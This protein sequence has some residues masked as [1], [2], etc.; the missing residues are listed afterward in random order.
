MEG[1]SGDETA[2]ASGGAA[3]APRRWT[4]DACGCHTNTETDTSCSICGT[5]QSGKRFIQRH[6]LHTP[7]IYIA[8]LFTVMFKC[9][10]GKNGIWHVDTENS[11][12]QS[13]SI[14]V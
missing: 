6:D 2:D 11:N 1:E 4:C 14:F 13:C 9:G 5:S 10:P 3:A 12:S 7:R 8:A